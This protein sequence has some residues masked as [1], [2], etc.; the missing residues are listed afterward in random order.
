MPSRQEPPAKHRPRTHALAV[1]V[2]TALILSACVGFSPTLDTLGTDLAAAPECCAD[3]GSLPTQALAPGAPLLLDV[4]PGSPAHRFETGKSYFRAVRLPAAAEPMRLSVESYMQVALKSIQTG[5]SYVFAPQVE[6]LDEA[7]RPLR[8]V[9][10]PGR[11]RH[12]PFGEFLGTRGAGWKLVVETD[13][14]AGDA[15]RIAVV[16]TTDALLAGFTPHQAMIQ[17]RLQDARI[18]HSPGGRLR[19]SLTPVSALLERVYILEQEPAYAVFAGATQEI[20]GQ[21]ERRLVGAGRKD[22]AAPAAVPWMEFRNGL[23]A[24]L[25]RIVER[26]DYP[27]VPLRQGIAELLVRNPGAPIGVTWNGGIAITARDYEYARRSYAAA[28]SAPSPT[29]RPERRADPL[30]P[31][32]HLGPLLGW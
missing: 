28:R 2:S 32:N 26:N 16:R 3:P 12:V 6:L 22:G 19:I 25:A 14:E 17:G 18:A 27:D 15:A 8:V 10:P 5:D 20:A 23:G 9:N 30:H 4:G 1:G 31:L 29:I 21:M 11:L 7:G 24:R 13:I